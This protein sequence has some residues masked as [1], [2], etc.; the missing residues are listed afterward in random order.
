MANQ[1][2]GRG[3]DE[4]QAALPGRLHLP[5]SGGH[6]I[7][8]DDMQYRRFGVI[9]SVVRGDVDLLPSRQ[10]SVGK[11][12]CV[13]KRQETDW[14]AKGRPQGDGM[15]F[16]SFYVC[17]QIIICAKKSLGVWGDSGKKTIYQR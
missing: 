11:D 16:E 13:T 17:L 6:V 1:C 5:A 4:L 3:D 15:M 2:S 14:T 9:F 12:K 8:L 7:H 10:K